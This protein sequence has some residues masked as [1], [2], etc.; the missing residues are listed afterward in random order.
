MKK[1]LV[2]IALSSGI[3]SNA[4]DEKPLP[5]NLQ[6]A[7]KQNQ[8]ENEP[9]P[10]LPDNMHKKARLFTINEDTTE[11]KENM[12]G[13]FYEVFANEYQNLYYRKDSD[14]TLTTM[15]APGP[16]LDYWCLPWQ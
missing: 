7:V 6:L 8:V 14:P 4:Q 10:T 1:F 9:R 11:I 2:I 15:P 5:D 3:C 12:S 16:N 13:N